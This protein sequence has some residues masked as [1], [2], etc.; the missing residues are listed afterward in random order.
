MEVKECSLCQSKHL[1]TTTVTV[2]DNDLNNAPRSPDGGIYLV[3]VYKSVYI[4]THCM[5]AIEETY[6]VPKLREQQE[7]QSWIVWSEA[8]MVLAYCPAKNFTWELLP[9]GRPKKLQEVVLP[10]W[11]R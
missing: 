4:C 10:P 8:G 1:P 6:F 7:Q 11:K 9:T 2:T 3:C 5:D